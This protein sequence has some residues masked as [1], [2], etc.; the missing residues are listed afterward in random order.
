MSFENLLRELDEMSPEEE[1]EEGGKS[2]IDGF[3]VKYRCKVKKGF[4][5]LEEEK[6]I[7]EF[8]NVCYR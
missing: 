6:T 2:K 4:G 7:E 8:E 3:E 1:Y 5:N